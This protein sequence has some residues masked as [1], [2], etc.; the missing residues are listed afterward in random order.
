M[1]KKKK[2][3]KKTENA[4]LKDEWIDTFQMYIR[5]RDKW[6]CITCGLTVDPTSETSKRDMHAG[7]FIGRNILALLTDEENVNAQCSSC[8]G[9][10]HW[11][12]NKEPYRNALICKYGDD[13]IDKLMMR[14]NIIKKFTKQSKLD[15]ISNW[16]KMI[17]QYKEMY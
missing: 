1:A 4:I 5:W 10:E 16:N 2:R 11:N 13:I 9:K 8:N 3:K 17:E 12:E 15:D 7:H 6:T 14:K